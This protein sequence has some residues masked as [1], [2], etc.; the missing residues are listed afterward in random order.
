MHPRVWEASGHLAGFTDPLVDCRKCKARFRADHLA[1]SQCPLKPSKAPGQFEKCDLTEARQFNLMFKTFMG[2]VEDTASVVY[3]RPETA[4]G[5]FVNFKNVHD[6]LAPEAPVRHRAD[7]Q[8]VPQRDHARQLPL[9]HARVRADGDGVL[10]QAG[11]GRAVVRLLDRGAPRLVRALRHPARATCACARTPPTSWRTTPRAAP[12]SSTTSRSAG[13]S[14]RASPTAPT[15]TCAATPSSAARTCAT[16]TRRRASTTS[17]T[18]SSR[19]P[20]PT[21]PRWRSWSTPTTRT[22]PTASRAPCCACTRR[23]RRSRSRSSRCCARTA[24]RR[25][26]ARCTTCCARTSPSTTTRPARSA[27]ATAARTRSARPFGITVDHQTMAGRHRDAAR[28]RHAWSRSACRSI[29]WSASSR[30][31]WRRRGPDD[32]AGHTSAL[33]GAAPSAP[34]GTGCPSPAWRRRRGALTTQPAVAT[35][36]GRPHGRTN[37]PQDG[38][39]G[40]PPR[41]AQRAPAA[42]SARKFV[43]A[44]GGGT[45]RRQRHDEGPARRQGRQPRRDGRPRPAGSARASRSPPRSAP[46]STRTAAATRRRCA[47]RSR[48][49]CARSRSWSASAS[50]I[51]ANP[52]LVS[53]R[54]GARASMPGMMDTVLNLGLNDATVQGLIALTGN[55]RFAYDS[56]PPLRADVRRR[57]ARPEA[58]VEGRDR[59]VRGDPR[60]EEA[61]PRRE[62]RHRARPPTTC[63][64]WSASSRPRSG[65]A[66][67]CSSPRIR[68]SSS[69]ARS[70]PSSA[71]GTTTAPSPTAS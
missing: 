60:A 29:G 39:P 52:L 71:R 15:S 53:V 2:P 6:R 28:P 32:V 11:R 66:A 30:S 63:A 55:A 31:D 22:S 14:S 70:A 37:Q 3:L 33:E 24:S 12:T 26:R 69:G 20:A 17:P 10:R 21:A 49:S 5:I 65:R 56:L 36:K 19:R 1:S 45:R 25:R 42:R 41:G 40:A 58:R 43:Y 7:R 68:R 4:Q 59:S 67:A 18:S 38:A 34:R 44:F 62:A 8:V 61:R 50:A 57:R 46:T 47:P 13:R 51:P 54:S 16:S 23:W 64:S 9:P 48:A 27:G 35:T